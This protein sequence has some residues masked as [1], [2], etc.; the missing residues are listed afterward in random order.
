MGRLLR[1]A[2]PASLCSAMLGRWSLGSRALRG[3]DLWEAH[4][5]WRGDSHIHAMRAHWP[6]ELSH[7]LLWRLPRTRLPT[8]REEVEVG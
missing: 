1:P 5:Q 3:G 6:S 2:L 8:R 7:E 4:R